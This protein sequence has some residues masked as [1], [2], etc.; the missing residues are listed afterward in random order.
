MAYNM[1]KGEIIK[2]LKENAEYF[3]FEQLRSF[4]LLQK[5]ENKVKIEPKTKAAFIEF[6]VDVKA[7][8]E[9]L[10]LLEK[11]S[12]NFDLWNEAVKRINKII[13]I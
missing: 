12:Q 8:C 5:N 7:E 9:K 13:A 10:I 1:E 4:E 3:P 6:F 2:Q 11:E